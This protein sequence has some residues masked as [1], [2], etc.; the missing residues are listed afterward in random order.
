MIQHAAMGHPVY[1]LSQRG[2]SD[3]L[4]HTSLNY[5]VDFE[6]YFDFALDEFALD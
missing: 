6:D 2:N 5:A 3:S 4:N 1:M